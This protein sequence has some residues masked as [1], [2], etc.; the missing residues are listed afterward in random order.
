[1]VGN[2]GATPPASKRMTRCGAC[3]RCASMAAAH[4]TPVPILREITHFK[5]VLLEKSAELLNV[6]LG[7]QPLANMF[8]IREIFIGHIARITAVGHFADGIDA[9]ER[10][11]SAAG[12]LADVVVG[13]E[14]LASDDEAL[15]RSRQI[16]V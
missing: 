8:F 5:D 10:D 3:I 13:D 11:G 9:K 15:G 1:M 12:I 2:C 16:K 6:L 4:G 7:A 14:T